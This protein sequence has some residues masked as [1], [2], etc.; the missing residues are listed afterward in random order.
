MTLPPRLLPFSTADTRDLLRALLVGEAATE[1]R[2]GQFAILCVVRNRTIL[3]HQTYHQ[4]V[5]ANS[6]FSC[7]WEGFPS[8]ASEMLHALTD[9]L[10][11][12][13]TVVEDCLAGVPDITD[14]ATNYA[15][16]SL[17]DPSWARHMTQTV[18]IAA[19]TFFKDG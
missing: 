5:L 1:P 16:L 19:H 9:R 8:R 12:I 2:D 7:F 10:S 4:V 14:G 18:K 15:N 17:C 11:P 13:S 6:Q 3:R